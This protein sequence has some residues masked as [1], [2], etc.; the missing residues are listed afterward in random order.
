MLI[1]SKAIVLHTLKYNDAS[2]VVETYTEREG[3]VAFLVRIPKTRR[4]AVKN[5]LFSPLAMLELEWNARPASSLQHVRNAK[6]YVVFTSI[7]YDPP[8]TCLAL[9]MAEF[10]CASLRAAQ[11]DE[12]MFAFVDTSVRW[13]DAA[14]GSCANFH[15]VFLLHLSHFLGIRPNLEDYTPGCFFD[16]Q[17]GRYSSVRPPHSHVLLPDEASLLPLLM[18]MKY[19][20]ASHFAFTRAQR[21]RLLEVINEYYSLHLPSFSGLKSPDVLHALFD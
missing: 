13:L 9:F 21:R 7:P 8:K 6:P 19:A 11:P 15:I 10:L 5:V 4:A 1:R 17:S 18:R 12:R 16:L 2:E 3:R 20:T 14:Q